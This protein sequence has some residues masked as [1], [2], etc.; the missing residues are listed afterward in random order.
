MP[1]FV[2]TLDGD[3]KII[4]SFSKNFEDIEEGCK[5][6]Y[7]GKMLEVDKPSKKTNK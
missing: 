2:K 7:L 1:I 6:V 4:S 3:L 5:L